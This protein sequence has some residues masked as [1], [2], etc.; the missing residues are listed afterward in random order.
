M[1]HYYYII[2][3]IGYIEILTDDIE[4]TKNSIRICLAGNLRKVKKEEKQ[5]VLVNKKCWNKRNNNFKKG[6]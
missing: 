1:F 5:K 2:I 4:K 6:R 3:S